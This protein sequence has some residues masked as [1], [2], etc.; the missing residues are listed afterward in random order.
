MAI[1]LFFCF[2][3]DE[4]SALDE[5][6]ESIINAVNDLKM[7]LP[8]KRDKDEEVQIET[9]TNEDEVQIET[10]TKSSLDTTVALLTLSDFW[11]SI[12]DFDPFQYNVIL[13]TARNFL[14]T[15]ENIKISTH[16]F[17]HIWVTL[18]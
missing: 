14:E 16:P 15:W 7:F 3:V 12:V 8:T 13:R 6:V 1:W 11:V 10:T 9:T 18:G 2:D 17:Y 5:K 4:Q